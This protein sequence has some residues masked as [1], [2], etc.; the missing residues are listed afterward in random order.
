MGQLMQLNQS[1]NNHRHGTAVRAH[2]RA[3]HAAGVREPTRW[4]VPLPVGRAASAR[5]WGVALTAC[6]ARRLSSSARVHENRVVRQR[7][8]TLTVSAS[9]KGG[10]GLARRE[11]F[12]SPLFDFEAGAGGCTTAWHT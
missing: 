12:L 1:I 6:V 10:G 2:G 5:C 7:I 9:V 3:S 4:R 8:S 11:A